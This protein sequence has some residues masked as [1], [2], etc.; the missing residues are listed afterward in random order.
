MFDENVLSGMVYPIPKRDRLRKS[1]AL[2]QTNNVWNRF[3]FGSRKSIGCMAQIFRKAQEAYEKDGGVGVVPYQYFENFYFYTGKQRHILKEKIGKN[4]VRLDYE[5]GR[6]LSDLH[7]IATDFETQLRKAGFLDVSSP[8][9]FN[10]VYIR[11]L[12]ES[13]IGFY[14]EYKARNVLQK[15]FPKF[16]FKNADPDMD[17]R[18]SIDIAVYRE[19]QLVAGFQVKTQ[20]YRISEKDYSKD[21]KAYNSANFDRCEQELGFRPEYLYVDAKGNL[22]EIPGWLAE[23]IR[24]ENDQDQKYSEKFY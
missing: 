20:Q 23:T 10:Y 6:T 4:V 13:Y 16:V 8:D 5:Y 18:Y 7:K 2:N 22:T 1:T 21:A 11:T 9:I 17:V 19:E 24:E 12:D 14:R 3:N 15:T